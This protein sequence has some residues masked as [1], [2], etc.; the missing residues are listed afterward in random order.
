MGLLPDAGGHGRDCARAGALVKTGRHGMEGTF[1]QPPGSASLLDSA[2]AMPHLAGLFGISRMSSL[3]SHRLDAAFAARKAEG[4]AAF[5]AYLCAGDPDL[6][7]T[8]G[9]MKALEAAG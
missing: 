3:P 5:V 9:I 1:L 4:R 8:L 6:P 2:T 7:R